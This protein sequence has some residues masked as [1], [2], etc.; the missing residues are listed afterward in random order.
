M[1]T[2]SYPLPAQ[3]NLAALSQVVKANVCLTLCCVCVC[4]NLILIITKQ[5][6][7]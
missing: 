6:D 1:M 2:Q 4:V 3:N 7:F 5:I